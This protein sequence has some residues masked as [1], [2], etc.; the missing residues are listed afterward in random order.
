[1]V[2]VAID[3]CVAFINHLPETT[4]ETPTLVGDDNR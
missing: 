2:V 4:E 3:K 1:L